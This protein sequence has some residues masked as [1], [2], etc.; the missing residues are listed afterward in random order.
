MPRCMDTLLPHAMPMYWGDAIECE[1]RPEFRRFVAM[2]AIDDVSDSRVEMTCSIIIDDKE[3]WVSPELTTS[4]RPVAIDVP[5]PK[6]SKKL[7]L[8]GN[9]TSSFYVMFVDWVNA[10]FLM[11]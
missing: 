7:E 8:K 3:V 11:Q 10:G 6:A 1:L 2:L 5:I 4:N 9:C